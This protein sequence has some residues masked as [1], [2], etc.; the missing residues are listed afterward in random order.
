M[1]MAR[2]QLEMSIELDR[3]IAME[4]KDCASRF[5]KAAETVG[6]G[7]VAEVVE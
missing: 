2:R 4:K 3:A 6:A 5:V 1:V 7:T